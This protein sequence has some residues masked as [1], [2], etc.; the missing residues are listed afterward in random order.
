LPNMEPR[1]A[2]VVEVR[3]NLG[4]TQAQFG[5]LLGVHEMTVSR[6]E[7]GEFPPTPYQQTLIEEF[8]KAAGDKEVKEKLLRFLLGAGFVAALLFV[9]NKAQKRR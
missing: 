5:Q 4:L 1:H 3:K 9:L 6:W 7:R 2:D 8:G